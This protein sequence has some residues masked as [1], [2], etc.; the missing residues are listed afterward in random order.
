MKDII[1]RLS[2]ILKGLYYWVTN[3]NEALSSNRLK[4]CAKCPHKRHDKFIKADY[5]GIC[6]CVLEMKSRV[7]SEHC[8]DPKG[9]RWII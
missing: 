8:P 4:I 2:S 1:I 7:L 9:N 3:N 5:C 6:D